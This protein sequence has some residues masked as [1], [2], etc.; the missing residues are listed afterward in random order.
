[1]KYYAPFIRKV[2]YDTQATAGSDGERPLPHPQNPMPH[3]EEGPEATLQLGTYRDGIR[4]RLR[5]LREDRPGGV[6]ESL[7]VRSAPSSS[8]GSIEL[9]SDLWISRRKPTTGYWDLGFIAPNIYDHTNLGGVPSAFTTRW[10]WDGFA[11]SKKNN[12]TMPTR[13]VNG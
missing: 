7:W 9:L 3:S 5:F 12:I 4:G 13:N 8:Q 1:M 11:G 6:E 2:S 10:G